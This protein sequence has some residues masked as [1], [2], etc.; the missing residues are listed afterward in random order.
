MNRSKTTLLAAIKH[1]TRELQN[2]RGGGQN[3][4]PSRST[5]NYTLHGAGDA[6]AINTHAN[7]LMAGAG[8]EKIRTN[9]VLAVEVLFSLPIDRHQHDTKPF[10]VDCYNWTL[11][12]FA[13]EL[14]CFHV[15]L[16]ES[17]PHAHALILP[18]IDGKLRGNQGVLGDKEKIKRIRESY[19]ANVGA[20]HGLSQHVYRRFTKADK[21]RI[22]KEVL[23]RLN[24]DSV[25]RSAIFPWARDS[26]VENPIP[27]AELLGI[28]CIPTVKARH[29]ID[30]KRSRGKGSFE[31]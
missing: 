1:N 28:A 7:V 23:R 26:I 4:N 11:K 30:I 12:T 27:C 17:A 25:Q 20:K 16:D 22:A 13:G 8:I 31:T 15:H 29:F 18:L 14:L 19:F 5:L 21:A 2:E 6:K 24:S 9:A 3:I 10:F